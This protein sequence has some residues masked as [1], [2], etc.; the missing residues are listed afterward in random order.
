VGFGPHVADLD[1]DG[2][3]DILSGSYPGELYLFAGKEGGDFAKGVEIRDADG[4]I[5]KVGR[6][7][8]V[9]ATDWEGDGDLDLVVGDIEGRVQLVPNGSG[10]GT[11]AFGKPREIEVGGEPIRAPGRN[12]GPT[13]ADWDGDGRDDL[14]V[15]C[16]DGTVLFYR[17]TAKSGA[18]V[19]AEPVTLVPGGAESPTGSRAKVAVADWNG[20]G[21]LDLL[22]GDF[23]SERPPPRELT[24]EQAARRD[25]LLAKRTKA[26]ESLRERSGEIYEEARPK[27]LDEFG[28]T[29]SPTLRE[30]YAKLEPDRREDF[31]KR[32]VALIQEDEEY[33][34]RLSKYRELNDEV[35]GYEARATLHGYVWLFLRT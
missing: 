12:S 22:L 30:V 16:G 8:V 11:M 9:V 35:R 33:Q 5:L 18:P 31:R 15:G 4:E 6:A 1:G 10:D 20:D 23:S 27:L 13:I 28:L 26:S 2:L 29:G 17:D 24:P 25:E 3:R 19:L 21:K 14:V 7:T 32:L 34:A